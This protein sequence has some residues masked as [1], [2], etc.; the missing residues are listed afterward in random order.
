MHRSGVGDLRGDATNSGV[1]Q[2]Q[3]SCVRK[4]SS[5]VE[6]CFSSLGGGRN[7]GLATLR[8]LAEN[9]LMACLMM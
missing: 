8:T 2:A 5:D 3:Q 7:G 1:A 9:T 4:Q 6:V